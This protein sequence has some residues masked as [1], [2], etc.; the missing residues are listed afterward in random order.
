MGVRVT[1]GTGSADCHLA[2]GTVHVGSMAPGQS[3]ASTG[4]TRGFWLF[5]PLPGLTHV[6]QKTF[7]S[8]TE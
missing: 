6:S 3:A 5:D 7:M 2:T 1:R 8:R 4:W